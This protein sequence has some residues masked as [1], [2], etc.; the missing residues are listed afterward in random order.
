MNKNESILEKLNKLPRDPGVYLMKDDAGNIIY[1]G[2][3]KDLRNRVRQYFNSSIQSPKTRLMVE[4]IWDFE[5]IVVNTEVEAFILEAT[6]IKDNRPKYNILLKDDKEYPYIKIHNEPFPKITKVRKILKDGGK[7]F[8]PY[9]NVYAVNDFLDTIGEFFKLRTCNRD[10]SKV[11]TKE[12]ACLYMHTNRCQAPCQGNITEEEY[13][14]NIKEI[15]RIISTKDKMKEIEELLRKEMIK[16]SEELNFELASIYRDRIENIKLLYEEQKMVKNSGTDQDI[17]A[18]SIGHSEAISQVFFIRQGTIMGR[19]FFVIENI[20]E[21]SLDEILK[22]FLQQFYFGAAFL[23]DEIVVEC[24]P[25][26]LENI[27][28]FLRE[29][30]GANVK[31]IVPKKGV[32]WKLLQMVKDNANMM[33]VKHGDRFIKEARKNKETLEELR[34]ILGLDSEISRIESFD[35]SHIQGVD[36]VGGMVVFEKGMAKKSDYRRFKIRESKK[37]DDYGAMEEMLFRRFKRLGSGLGDSFS[38]M[39][40]LILMDGGIGQ[41]NVC[42][43]ILGDLNLLIPVA[44]MVKDELHETRGLYYKGEEYLF[45]KD[46]EVYKLLYKVQ[47]EVHRYAISFHRSLR[48][49]RMFKSELDG[50]PEIGPKR[51]RALLEY[52]KDISKIKEADIETLSKVPSMTKKSA[53]SLYDYFRN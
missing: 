28:G 24:M 2:K 27:E 44:G 8:G 6:L 45:P 30:K 14:N 9:P 19:E 25:L 43:R 18:I 7:Y 34:E 40:D 49:K 23:P 33:M 22:D 41:V 47:E 29:K 20:E 12:R 46:S 5:Y 35:I 17:I 26:D 42:E 13:L 32:N 52:F 1:V 39:P 11:P 51:K 37:S 48:N 53:K 21:R 3:A 4:N 36:T 38:F 50:I 10:L 31:I 15:E 16:A